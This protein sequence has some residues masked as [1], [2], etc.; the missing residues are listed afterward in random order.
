MTRVIWRIAAR[1]YAARSNRAAKSAADFKARSEKF[2]R[3]IK[4]V[5]Q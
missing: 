4:G 3:K 2:F 5:Y 1:Y